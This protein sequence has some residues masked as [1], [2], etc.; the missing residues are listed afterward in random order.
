MVLAGRCDEDL[1]VPYQPIV[2]ALGHFLDHTPPE[3]VRPRLGRLGGEVARLVPELADRAPGLAPPLRSDPETERYRLFDAVAAWLGA[4]SIE[5]PLLLVLDDLHWVPRPTLLLL[6]HIVRSSGPGR[7]L[8]VGTYRDTELGTGHPLTELLADL[9]RDEG[10]ERLGLSG[11]EVAEVLAVLEQAAGHPLDDEERGLARTVHTETEGK[12]PFFVWEM[13]R[14]FAEIGAV[15]RR[16]G[17][18]FAGQPLAELGIPEGVRDVVGRRLSRLSETANGVLTT[19]AVVGIEFDL[20]TIRTLGALDDGELVVALDDAVTARLVQERGAGA[21]RFVHA[22]VRSTLYDALSATRRAQLHLAV[23]GAL[24]A[25]G[26]DDPVRVAHHL[27][28]AGPLAEATQTA[29]ACLAAGDRALSALADAEALDWFARGLPL[30][31]AEHDPGLHVDLL[32]GLGQA[33]RRL[34]DTAASRR[35]LLDAAR[36]AAD[37]HD[38]GRLVRAVLANNRLYV[39]SIGQVDQEYLELI[40]TALQLVGHAAPAQRAELL[41]LQAAQMLFTA[42]REGRLRAADEAAAIAAQ[43]GDPD[44][45]AWVGV[46]RFS[47]CLV[48]DRTTA[49][50]AEGIELVGLAD[51]TGDP[52]L[53]VWS[54]ALTGHALFLTGELDRALPLAGEGMAIADET[55]EPG[56]RCIAHCFYGAALEAVGEHDEGRRLIDAFPGLGLQAGWPDVMVWYLPPMAVDAIWRGRKDVLEGLPGL[57]PALV[58]EYPAFSVL[59]HVV[60]PFFLAALDHRAEELAVCLAAVPPFLPALPVDWLWLLG[61]SF[62]TLGMSFGVE[63]RTAAA[64]VYENLL[65]Y[66]S[67][68][69]AGGCTVYLFPI[70]AALAITAR[71]MG[72]PDK[73]LAHHE[74][75]ATAIEACGGARARALNGYQWARTLLARN[76]PGDRRQA[77]ALL[78]ETLEYSRTKGYTFLVEKCEELTEL[79]TRE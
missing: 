62:L 30:V 35:S 14:H 5:R 20:V 25:T 63:D 27:L 58:A 40:S 2:E 45:R 73:A 60:E 36:L 26:G 38:E 43:L 71:V 69:G 72:D 59:I 68:H 55:G 23:A 19:A 74:A 44:L 53:R 18:W 56:L 51:T 54:R 64:L 24:E 77:T 13:V 9:R 6:R 79:S 49:M 11:L 16:E 32:T 76:A 48:P 22:L 50:A 75:A 33:Q 61:Q 67:L 65:P 47:A 17:R 28:A 21:Y 1:G 70:E 39:G 42:D 66:R 78:Q 4:A 41:A 15:V 29:R 52:Q 7:I 10:V 8:V 3:V 34:G 46:R 31:T 12:N 57:L 37:H